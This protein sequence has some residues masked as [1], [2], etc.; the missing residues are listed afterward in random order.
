V[1]QNFLSIFHEGYDKSWD[2]TLMVKMSGLTFKLV[3][4]V[5]GLSFDDFPE[6]VILQAKRCIL[7]LLGCALGAYGIGANKHIVDYVIGLGGAKEADIWGHGHKVPCANAALANGTFTHHIELDDGN[8]FGQVHSG[9]TVIPAAMAIAQK[10]GLDGKELI[11][12]IIAG[13]EI[14]GRIGRAVREEIQERGIHGPGTVGAFGAAVASAKLLDLDEEGIANALGICALTPVAPYEAFTAGGLVKDLYGGWPAFLGVTAALLARMGY[15]GPHTLIEGGLGYCR[16][17][18]RD[19][20]SSFV[21][22]GLGESY[23]IM[24]TYFKPYPSSRNTH[25]VIDATLEI[26]QRHA[27]ETKE[28]RKIE[29]RTY[30][31]AA[32]VGCERNPKT[33]IAAL[34][35]IPYVIAVSILDKQVKLE[36]FTEAKVKDRDLLN[37]ARK[38]IVKVDPKLNERYPKLRG[39]KVTIEMKDGRRYSA[40]SKI[41]RGDPEKPLSDEELE[42]KFRNLAMRTLDE[43]RVDK[44]ISTVRRLED[45]KNIEE[46]IRLM[47]PAYE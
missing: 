22:K 35:S 11:T 3:S 40:Y 8:K 17:F 4:F 14:G 18:K 13:Y 24:R 47:N 33:A 29:V 30:E 41:P 9:V 10:E 31:F 39:A 15:T 1:L 37:L 21:L 43:G 36:H 42:A 23:E 32:K 7:D 6:E 19:F 45:L 5:K 25:A 38:V 20:R 28:I 27:I 12:S 26:I 16:S 44:M 34:T 2:E 46:L